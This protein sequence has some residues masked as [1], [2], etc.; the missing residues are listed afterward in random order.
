MFSISQNVRLSVCLSV[1]LF[2]FE[3]PF[4][5]LFAPTSQ[6]RMSNIF[7]D[8]EFLGKSNGKKWSQMKTFL[9]E[10]CLKSPRKKSF[11]F[12]DFALQNMVET[13]LPDGLETSGWRAYRLFWHISRRFWVFAFWMIVFRFSIKS[14]FW[15]F[16]VQQN[17]VETMLSGGLETS[18]QRRIANFVIFL[19]VFEFLRFWWYFFRFSKKSGFLGILSPPSYGIVLLSASVERCFVSRIRDFFLNFIAPSEAVI[20]TPFCQN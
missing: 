15:L 14:G 3:V 6:S 20:I 12:A 19:D 11:F 10:N 18:G 4:K 16:F 1:C 2:T 7:R 13:T 8:S 9:F 17:M 5:H